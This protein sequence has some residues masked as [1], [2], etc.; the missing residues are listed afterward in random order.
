MTHSN[1]QQLKQWMMESLSGNHRSYRLLLEASCEILIGYFRN[2][3]YKQENIDDVVQE[4]LISIDKARSTF[5]PSM[6]YLNW[7]YSIAYRRYIDYVR[8][9]SRIDKMEVPGET[10]LPFLAN[11][12]SDSDDADQEIDKDAILAAIQ[13]LPQRQREIV[14]LLKVDGFSVREAAGIL[15]MTETAL[16]VAAHRAYKKIR[17][18]FKKSDTLEEEQA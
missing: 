18:Q 1:E 11:Q 7:M 8:K 14:M 15:D 2:R 10:I 9:Q 12:E 5:N 3:L 4:T 13:Q 17:A 16:K 6:P